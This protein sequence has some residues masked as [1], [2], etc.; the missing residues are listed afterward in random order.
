MGRL[1][2]GFTFFDDRNYST[3][4]VIKNRSLQGIELFVHDYD[5]MPVVHIKSPIIYE[6][7]FSE[8]GDIDKLITAFQIPDSLPDVESTENEKQT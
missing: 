4:V 6:E 3:R 2:N 1:N 7:K 8:E 5:K